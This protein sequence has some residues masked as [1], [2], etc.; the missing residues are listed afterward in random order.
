MLK[1]IILSLSLMSCPLI[2]LADQIKLNDDAPKIH[3]VVKGD[4][5]WDI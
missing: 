2:A 1:K 4:T 3:V 5:L